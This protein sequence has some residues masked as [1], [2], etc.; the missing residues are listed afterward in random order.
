MKHAEPSPPPLPGFK[1]CWATVKLPH[2]KILPTQKLNLVGR[3]RVNFNFDKRFS[4]MFYS[5]SVRFSFSNYRPRFSL[6]CLIFDSRLNLKK[7][8]TTFPI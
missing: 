3:A 6:F 7:T 8:T 4:F 2:S 1:G 5:I